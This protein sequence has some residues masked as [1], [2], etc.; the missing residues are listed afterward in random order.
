MNKVYSKETRETAENLRIIDDAFFRILAE[1][2]E[3]CQEIL[4]TL[5]DNPELRVIRSKAQVTETS[6]HREITMDALC[7]TQ[8]NKLFNVEMQKGKDDDVPRTRFHASI[9]TSNHTPKGTKFSNIPDVTIVYVSEYDVLK[10][11]RMITHV[12]RCMETED[13]QYVPVNDGEDIVFANTCIV[14]DSDKSRLLQLMLRKD[15]FYD[16]RFPAVSNAVKYYKETKGGQEEMCEAVERLGEIFAEKA[17]AENRIEMIRDF[18]NSGASA[19]DA[20]RI[21]KA[22]SEELKKAKALMIQSV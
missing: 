2:E 5:L 15:A 14:D 8:D 20:V 18:L 10:N 4:Q 13:G 16:E 21:F 6:L 9:V 12:T 1:K 17:V 11:N 7:I 3:V 19:E 22:S